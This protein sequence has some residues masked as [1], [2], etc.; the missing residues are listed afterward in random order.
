MTGYV[1]I[2]VAVSLQ[3]SCRAAN[4]QVIVTLD[5]RL[6]AQGQKNA[7][8]GVIV[9]GILKPRRGEAGMRRSKIWQI[10]PNWR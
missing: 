6:S 7:R 4:I 1:L 10:R 5:I 8:S 9:A 2:V 3:T